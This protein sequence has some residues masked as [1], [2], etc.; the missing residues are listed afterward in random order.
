MGSKTKHQPAAA[1]PMNLKTQLGPNLTL[2]DAGVRDYVAKHFMLWLKVSSLIALNISL[3]TSAF[4]L[5]IIIAVP[6]AFGKLKNA[7]DKG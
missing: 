3:I 5:I 1:H 6:L 4:N 2:I 7:L